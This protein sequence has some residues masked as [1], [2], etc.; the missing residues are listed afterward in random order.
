MRNKIMMILALFAVMT[1]IVVAT[2]GNSGNGCSVRNEHLTAGLT[3]TVFHAEAWGTCDKWYEIRLYAPGIIP[4]IFDPNNPTTEQKAIF[5]S[6]PDPLHP[7][8]A[9]LFPA[10]SVGNPTGSVTDYFWG[11]KCI[12]VTDCVGTYTPSIL[13]QG[14]WIVVLVKAGES[15]N[16]PEY[17][18]SYR[19]ST[20]VPVAVPE[21]STIALPIAGVIGLVFF[22]QHKKRKEE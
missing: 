4:G 7:Y 10:L 8:N 18:T 14:D 9:F 1:G 22:F 6:A 21:F 12:L 15:G 17:M 16:P 5:E 19:L 20:T 3:G 2:P 11:Q 13:E